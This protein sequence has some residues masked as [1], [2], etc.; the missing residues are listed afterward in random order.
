MKPSR[1]GAQHGRPV[2]DH[3][4]HRATGSKSEA[5]AAPVG[6]LRASEMGYAGE[7]RSAGTL[8]TMPETSPATSNHTVRSLAAW[9]VEH[10]TDHGYDPDAA[11]VAA[12]RTCQK[13][14]TRL[15]KRLPRQAVSRY[16]RA[17]SAWQRPRPRFSGAFVPA[18]SPGHVSRMFRTMRAGRRASKT[19]AGLLA[20]V[21]HLLGLLAVFIGEGMTER[22]VR[23][24]CGQPES[25]PSKR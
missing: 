18:R 20:V 8:G 21:A 11:L 10:E 19:Q 1:S 17:R 15:A 13:L 2:L 5:S 22:L 7:L 12:E 24:A 6:S 14:C 16:L 25:L 3:P 4:A 9:L 23:D